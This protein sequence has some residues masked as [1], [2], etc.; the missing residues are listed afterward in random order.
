MCSSFCQ[1]R[2]KQT[3]E[4]C[5]EIWTAPDRNSHENNVG[6]SSPQILTNILT[7]LPLSQAVA[8]TSA[9]PRSDRP[10]QEPYLIKN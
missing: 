1:A 7:T 3:V 4:L 2:P 8:D 5:V 10:L 6:P 9:N